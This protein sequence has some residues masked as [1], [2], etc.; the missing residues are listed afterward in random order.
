MFMVYL[1]F[2]T[3]EKTLLMFSNNCH[4]MIDDGSRTPNGPPTLSQ[5]LVTA[6]AS[7][8]RMWGFFLKL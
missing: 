7:H 2:L 6:L 4:T 8:P 1:L 3:L 5:Y